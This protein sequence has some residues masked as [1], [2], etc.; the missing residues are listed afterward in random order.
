MLL[1]NL[2]LDFKRKHV[3]KGAIAH[4]ER[5]Q[6]KVTYESNTSEDTNMNKNKKLKQTKT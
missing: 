5:K 6:G 3:I 2:S 1:L 4:I